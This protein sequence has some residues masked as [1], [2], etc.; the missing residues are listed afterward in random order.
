MVIGL[1]ANSL[2]LVLRLPMRG[3]LRRSFSSIKT[4]ENS[5]FNFDSVNFFEDTLNIGTGKKAT[6]QKTPEMKAE[7]AFV[8]KKIE[9]A[10]FLLPEPPVELVTDILISMVI[11]I[12]KNNVFVNIVD[13]KGGVVFR[14]TAKTAGSKTP[15]KRGIREGAVNAVIKVIQQL[16]ECVKSMNRKNLDIVEKHNLKI[17]NKGVHLVLVGSSN[18]KFAIIQTISEQGLNVVKLTDN[19]PIKHGGSRPRKPKRL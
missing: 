7:K 19:T 18:A 4:N 16:N 5:K 11:S 10:D 1:K 15:G 2:A 17:L 9:P 8:I 13:D 6:A 14:S 3:L 12:K